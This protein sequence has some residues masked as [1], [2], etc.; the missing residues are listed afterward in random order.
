MSE[1]YDRYSDT[2]F[3]LASKIVK[4]DEIAQDILQDSFIKIWKNIENYS[5]E[6]GSFFTW[7]LNITRN[8]AIDAIRKSK[9]YTA[10]SIQDV[11]NS[12]HM[13]GGDQINTNAI[14]LKDLVNNL[15]EDQRVRGDV[16]G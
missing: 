7:M 10:T 11:E 16:H 5:A 2:L 1:L 13:D 15:Q 3:G 9:K 8:T 14:G 12:V 4:S 6:K